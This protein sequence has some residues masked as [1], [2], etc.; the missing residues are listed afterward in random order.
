MY[1]LPFQTLF[2]ICGLVC[3]ALISCAPPAVKTT[4]L[5]PAKFHE[6]TKLTT[7]AVLPFDGP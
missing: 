5:V 2:I 6:A 1:K 4:A 3:L 7:V